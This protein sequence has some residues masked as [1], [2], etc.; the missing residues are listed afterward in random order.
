[1]PLETVL[2]KRTVER[3]SK[4]P[5]GVRRGGGRRS[6]TLKCVCAVQA[7][8]LAAALPALSQSQAASRKGFF[9]CLSGQSLRLKGDLT[10][11]RTLWHIDKAFSVPSMENTFG[12]SLGFGYRR[13]GGLWEFAV[14]HAS[15]AILLNGRSGRA[16][17]YDLELNGWGFPWKNAAVQPY[18]LLGL[19]FPWLVVTDGARMGRTVN[20]ATY[21]GLGINLGAGLLINLG[22]SLFLSGGVK[23]RYVGFFYVSGGGKGR[24]V[25]TL[26]VGQGGPRWGKWLM[27]PSLGVTFHFGF[28]V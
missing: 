22:P 1:M 7:L 6:K 28:R 25:T 5:R 11:D 4:P 3:S 8:V 2:T 20:D 23:Y 10:G 14:A 21:T 12:L 19:C 13:E 17:Y 24:D 27:A 18:Y 9:L 26:T 15:P 16:S